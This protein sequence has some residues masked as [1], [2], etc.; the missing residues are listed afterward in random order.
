MPVFGYALVTKPTKPEEIWHDC[1]Y[2]KTDNRIKEI[3]R[4]A[5]DFTHRTKEV[6]AEGRHDLPHESRGL[7]V[8]RKRRD[9]MFRIPPEYRQ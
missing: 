9:T 5:Q 1:K 7:T 2:E 8:M 3:R 4:V 6:A